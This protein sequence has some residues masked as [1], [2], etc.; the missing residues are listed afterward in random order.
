MVSEPQLEPVLSCCASDA[1]DKQDQLTCVSE[2]SA[3]SGSVRTRGNISGPVGLKRTD[4]SGLSVQ[5]AVYEAVRLFYDPSLIFWFGLCVFT[6]SEVAPEHFSVQKLGPSK[7]KSKSSN[8][9]DET[10]LQVVCEILYAATLF[11]LLHSVS[12]CVG[13]CSGLLGRKDHVTAQDRCYF[14]LMSQ[15]DWKCSC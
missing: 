10:I 1:L 5:H 14:I 13:L 3:S 9:L 12:C 15:H 11:L 6:F 8:D 2:C 4:S 7:K